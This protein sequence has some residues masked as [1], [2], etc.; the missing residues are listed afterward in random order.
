MEEELEERGLNRSKKYLFETALAASK[1]D[2]KR[3]KKAKAKDQAKKEGTTFGWDMYNT[4]SLYR[5][6]DKR[7]AKI[8]Q[9]IVQ[10]GVG[11]VQHSEL[12]KQARIEMMA[13]EVEERIEKR[14]AFSRRRPFNDDKDVSS[15]NDRNSKFNQKLERNYSKYVSG[16]KSNLERGS[17]L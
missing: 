5:A 8:P 15:I 2:K 11:D 6:Y 14:N 16:I 12:E 10:S 17:A 9:L 7:V 4:D 13:K 3:N 1:Q